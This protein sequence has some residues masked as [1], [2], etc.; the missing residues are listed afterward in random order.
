MQNLIK[1]KSSKKIVSP[2][3]DRLAGKLQGILNALVARKQVHHAVIAVECGD[4]S[5]RWIGTA[6]EAQPGGEPMRENTPF[7]IASVT[8]LYIASAILK[9]HERAMINLDNPI[10]DYLP[11]SLIGGIHRLKGVDYTGKITIRHLLCHTSGLPDWLEDRPKG[12]KGLLEQID[13]EEDRLISIE[14]AIEFVR[15]K[16]VPHFPPQPPENKRKKVR[17]SDTNF[18][19]LIAILERRMEK[20][21]HLV[22]EELLYRPLGLRN[23]FHPGHQPAENIPEFAAVWVG[24]KSFNKPLLMQSFRDLYSTVNDQ[25][26]FMRAL[27]S[28]E[29]FHEPGTANLMRQ[30]WNR[31]GFPR[32]AAAIRLPGWPI[33]Y[34]LG[35]M[36]LK[37]PR[38]FTPFKPVP[39]VIG[40]TGVSGSWLFYCPEL[41]L[42]LCGT[43]DQ[44]TAAALP[45]R[46]VPKLL[47]VVEKG[48]E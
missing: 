45:F 34:G 41:D 23:T 40:H 12:G 44:I 27:I 31:F 1:P 4:R 42:Y 48:R 43:V 2:P 21:V 16:L 29:V 13:K 14:E 36:R 22:F 35:M 20:P 10:T 33:E 39:A 5:F 9:L 30:Q 8:K 7:I 18:Q 28:G 15:D 38:L 32:D 37:M 24:D 26:I 47:R 46:F 3:Q 11:E 6:G 25:F 17:Y 19:L